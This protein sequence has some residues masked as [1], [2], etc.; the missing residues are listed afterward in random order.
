[1]STIAGSLEQ[2]EA[3]SRQFAQQSQTVDQLTSTIR[4]QLNNALWQGPAADR[5]RS[6]WSSEFEPVLRKL[7]AGLQEAGTEVQRR[8]DALQVAGT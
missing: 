8:K 2:L 1:M 7:Q 6:A 4:G 3:L 5:F